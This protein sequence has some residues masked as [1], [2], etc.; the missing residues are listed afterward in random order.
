MW[1]Y[2]ILAA[3]IVI[4]FF[5]YREEKA[6]KLK[7]EEERIMNGHDKTVETVTEEQSQVTDIAEEEIIEEA[8][9]IDDK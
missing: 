2:M 9:I 5:Y 8:E 4:T 7:K 3:A 6:K 1:I